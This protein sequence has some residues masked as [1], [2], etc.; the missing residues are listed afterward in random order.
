DAPDGL[1]A[2]MD[3]T[4]VQRA[5]GNLVANALAYTLAGGQVRLTAA[6]DGPSVRIEVTDTGRGIPR[7]HLPHVFDRFYR[8]DDARSKQSGGVGLGVAIVKS[9]AALHRGSAAIVS[10]AGRGTRV[11]LVFPAGN[12]GTRG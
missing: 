1:M 9:I 2:D 5:V 8:V 10:E 6:R 3:R 4:L 7:E 12:Q 11:T